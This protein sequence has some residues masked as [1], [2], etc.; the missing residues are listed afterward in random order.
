[1]RRSHQQ[2]HYKESIDLS[3]LPIEVQGK[4]AR[5]EA[6]TEL[7]PRPVIEI[8]FVG[9]VIEANTVANTIFPDLRKLG[10]K[11]PYLADLAGIVARLKKDHR[12]FTREVKI[13]DCWYRQVFYYISHFNL[14]HVYGSDV[15]DRKETER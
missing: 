12:P 4:L 6:F 9:N 1:M 10:A 11:H 5:L 15:T 13:G 2:K 3:Q 8:D 7:N 14:I